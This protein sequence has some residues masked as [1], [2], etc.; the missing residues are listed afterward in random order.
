[1][2]NR[3]DYRVFWLGGLILVLSKSAAAN[4]EGQNAEG[5]GAIKEIQSNEDYRCR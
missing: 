1:M 3:R 2:F 5:V 4:M